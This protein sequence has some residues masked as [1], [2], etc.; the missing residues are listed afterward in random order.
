M[1]A[2]DVKIEGG[3]AWRVSRDESARR[4]TDPTE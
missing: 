1:A 3:G 4:Y 2:R